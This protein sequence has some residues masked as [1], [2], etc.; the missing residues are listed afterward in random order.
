MEPVWLDGL[1]SMSVSPPENNENRLDLA[2][3]SGI[4]VTR[5]RPFFR[6]SGRAD[7]PLC[8]HS[9]GLCL[10]LNQGGRRTAGITNSV[11]SNVWAVLKLQTDC[12][13][14]LPMGS[15]EGEK[16]VKATVLTISDRAS[17]GEYEDIS[18]TEIIRILTN[19]FGD[20][21]KCRSEIV[22][23]EAESITAALDRAGGVEK[24][25]GIGFTAR[26]AHSQP[27]SEPS[28]FIITTGGTGIDPRDITPETC[29]IWCE[30]ELPGISE[31]L[32]AESYKETVTSVLSRGFAGLRDRTL[33]VNFPGSVK[34]VRLCTQLMLPVLEHASAMMAGEGH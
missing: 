15:R 25:T 20:K 18:G 7:Y 29:R 16:P 34:A 5:F 6:E 1:I 8:C 24:V 14:S 11:T 32:R 9:P 2:L 22:P 33:V 13:D 27:A 31:M 21:L 19:H 10:R 4:R 23:D 30:K 3:I 28:D 26:D 12:R 17:R